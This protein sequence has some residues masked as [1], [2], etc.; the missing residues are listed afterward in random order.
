M[1]GQGWRHRLDATGERAALAIG[2]AH[3]LPDLLARVL[4]SRR[5]DSPGCEA[6]L[7]PSLRGLMPDPDTL[8]DMGPATDRLAE[9]VTTGETIGVIG[10]Y[11]VDGASSAALLA[12]YLRTAGL[13]CE[14]HIPDRIR[15][16]YG[17]SR[18]AID[19]L[20]ASGVTLL[21]TV[22]CGSASYEP[23]RHAKNLGLDTL[24]FDHHQIALPFPPARAIVNPNRPDDLSGLGALCAAGVVFMV[25]VAL[26]RRLK[27]TS[28]WA[29]RE[30][31]DLL[32]G[33]DLVALATVADVVPLTGLN[34]A[35]VV[36]GLQV[37]RQRTRPGLAAL[38][39]VAG[40]DGP[41]TVF[42]LGYLIAP[43]INAG[44][45]IGEAALGVK[46]LL[47]ADKAQAA[48]VAVELDRLNRDRRLIETEAVEHAEAEALLMLDGDRDS[49]V[50]V[51]ARE[52]W[53]PGVMGLVAARLK[54]R[55]VRPAFA[56]ALSGGMG[57]G[58]G[59][60]IPGADLGRA[61]RAGVEAGLLQRGGGHAMAAGLTIAADRIAPF[62]LFLREHFAE[63]V[64]T[65]R[66]AE[67]LFVD[68]TLSAG[69]VTPELIAMLEPAGPFGA[70]SPEPVLAFPN[71]RVVDLAP[72]GE[73]HLRVML[74]APDGTRLRAMAFRAAG[75]P[76]ADGLVAT[77]GRSIHAVGT[78]TL[79][80]HGGG[81]P[82]AE[83]RLL[84]AAVPH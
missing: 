55:F 49:P 50:L 61:V 72:V 70:G 41:P 14:I 46:L 24:V 35:F 32:A 25:L 80:R 66:E 45:R 37:M 30:A 31:P 6:Y 12:D 67:A 5:V 13:R 58:S 7:S 23:L 11:D 8:T 77:R 57:T 78:L 63:R 15:E 42:H 68:A 56:I 47:S 60:S 43:R 65:L 51:A 64:G 10:D 75:T 71:H 26:H 44:G 34:R 16:G 62:T 74:A 28:F 52:G 3:G 22:D 83:L 59:R 29:G 73:D 27:A 76:L 40:L 69:A 38:F 18:E 48:I 84:D 17:P 33:L 21:V 1:R 81:E 9:A 4:A 2:Q 82:R 53:H 36:K 39:D 54:E 19:R 20:A 79:N